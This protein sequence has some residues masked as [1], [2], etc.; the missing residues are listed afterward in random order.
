MGPGE[1]RRARGIADALFTKVQQRV[2]GVLFA[3]TQRVFYLKELIQLAGVGTGA[4]HREIAKLTEAGIVTLVRVGNQTRYQANAACPVFEELRGLVQKTVGVADVLRG[5]L[6]KYSG[7]I[8]SAFVFGS[9]AAH[10]DSATSD[11]D[12]LVLADELAYA[13]LYAALEPATKVLGR[14]VNPTLYSRQEFIDRQ[15]SGNAFVSRVMESP[16]L[17]I[18]G[19]EHELGA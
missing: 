13:D 5:V 10:T 14:P 12:V 3:N 15:R 1:R 19:G 18:I 7:D 8:D 6:S 17:W 16:K 9:V 4:V 11:I 2:L